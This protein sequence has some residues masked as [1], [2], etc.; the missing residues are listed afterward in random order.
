[1]EITFANP[2]VDYMLSGI[3]AFQAEGESDFWSDPL[4]HFYP[5]LDKAY[6]ASLSFAERKLYIERTMRAVYVDLK[7]LYMLIIGASANLKLRQR[8]QMLLV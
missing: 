8:C 2:G 5:Q 4:Y 1:M 3:M 7:Q 6:A